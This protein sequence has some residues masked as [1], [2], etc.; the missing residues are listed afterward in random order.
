MEVSN[1]AF[2]DF[3]TMVDQYDALQPFIEE[4]SNS[5]LPILNKCKSLL[6]AA[7]HPIF[8]PSKCLIR[9]ERV[10]G[11]FLKILSK[12]AI[13]ADEIKLGGEIRS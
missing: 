7:I 11:V 10:R 8:A 2:M 4:V 13:L 1:V 9:R 3:I 12:R 5:G 6:T